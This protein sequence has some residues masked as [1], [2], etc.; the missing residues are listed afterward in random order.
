MIT[1][2]KQTFGSLLKFWDKALQ[3]SDDHEPPPNPK[4]PKISNK[5]TKPSQLKQNTEKN[6]S[7]DHKVEDTD[8]EETDHDVQNLQFT[9]RPTVWLSS[10]SGNGSSITNH[11]ATKTMK[12]QVKLNDTSMTGNSKSKQ[13][14]KF[15]KQRLS[16]YNKIVKYNYCAEQVNEHKD[17]LLGA[18]DESLAKH[19]HSACMIQLKLAENELNP[20]NIKL[21]TKATVK[22]IDVGTDSQI[23]NEY[24]LSKRLIIILSFVSVRKQFN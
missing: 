5:L 16:N 11:E 9:T 6:E 19:L 18:K 24:D 23:E 21:K 22:N 2:L 4:C 7:S 1:L 15:D 14:I 13:I 8:I 12:S 20:I 10:N 3:G 17:S